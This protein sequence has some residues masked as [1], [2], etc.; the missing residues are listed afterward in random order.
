MVYVAPYSAV[1]TWALDLRTE[2]MPPT[3]P[4][5]VEF[6]PKSLCGIYLDLQLRLLPQKERDFSRPFEACRSL[7]GFAEL[8]IGVDA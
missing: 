7:Q 1:V 6:M 5:L 4:M 8:R 2:Y 3:V